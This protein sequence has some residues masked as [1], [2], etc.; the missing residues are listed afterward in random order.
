[1]NEKIKDE[2]KSTLL[3]ASLKVFTK[4]GFHA[5]KMNDIAEEAGTSYGLVY[6]YFRSKEE[7]YSY[8][9][10]HALT[11]ISQVINQNNGKNMEPIERITA[12]AQRVFD[13]IE[14]KEISGYYYALVM[15]ALTCESLPVSPEKVKAQTLGY[16][17]DLSL[18]IHEGQRK[19]Q[20]REGDPVEISLMCFSMLIGTAML[21]V[22]GTLPP[23]LNPQLLLRIL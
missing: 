14:N 23:S 13:S 1:M 22:A 17:Q 19:G 15:N 2:K 11:S 8:L 16:L 18:I 20:I 3:L 6:H 5:T 12:M 10:D 9:I 4:K 7:I 21:K